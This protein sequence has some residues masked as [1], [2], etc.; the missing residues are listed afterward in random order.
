VTVGWQGINRDLGIKMIE[1]FGDL[2]GDKGGV[3]VT[4]D[5]RIVG[6]HKERNRTRRVSGV[7]FEGEGTGIE[8]KR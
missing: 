2:R 1:V 8:S 6:E 4:S 5:L 7:I 3:G